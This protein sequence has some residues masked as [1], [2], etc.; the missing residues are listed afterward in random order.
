MYFIDVKNI[1]PVFIFILLYLL[2]I[3]VCSVSF[4]FRLIMNKLMKSMIL[5][6]KRSKQLF[7]LNLKKKTLKERMLSN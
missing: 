1:I 2:V 6:I 4:I 3:K 7:M 5:K